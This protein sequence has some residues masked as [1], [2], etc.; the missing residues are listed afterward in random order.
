MTC[1]RSSGGGLQRIVSTALKGEL[2]HANIGN[3]EPFHLE[4]EGDALA[5]YSSTKLT[6]GS[7]EWRL[8]IAGVVHARV[9]AVDAGSSTSLEFRHVYTG[10]GHWVVGVCDTLGVLD[11][12]DEGNSDG[13]RCGSYE[14][15]EEG[16]ELHDE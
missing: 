10:D 12:V 13:G 3:I 8:T 2:G 9:V 16:D 5:R 7:H 14:S 1:C 15:R 4:Q 11:R 6:I